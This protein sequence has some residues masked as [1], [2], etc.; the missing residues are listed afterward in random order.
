M[1]APPARSSA[2]DGRGGGGS[3]K[4]G[5][6]R[7]EAKV[8]AERPAQCCAFLRAAGESSARG[9][10]ERGC[11]ARPEQLL[12]NRSLRPRH[13]AG[14][15][16]CQARV[17]GGRGRPHRTFRGAR[18][19]CAERRG[20]RCLRSPSQRN[21][22][23][24]ETLLR[25]TARVRSGAHRPLSGSDRPEDRAERGAAP[26]GLPWPRPGPRIVIPVGARSGPAERPRCR[27]FLWRRP[28]RWSSGSDQ[29]RPVP[30]CP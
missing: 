6:A 26:R 8:S 27:G 15:G 13:A 23:V 5:Q 30:G 22:V 19:T 3:G 14:A 21:A 1:E 18:L 20:G 10:A 24:G 2:E 25:N 4:A 12:C 17:A 9:Q 29:D 7:G 16:G 11:P 28:R